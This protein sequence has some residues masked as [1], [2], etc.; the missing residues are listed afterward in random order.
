MC[1]SDEFDAIA[2]KQ[3]REAVYSILNQI[4][5]IGWHS[6]DPL[7]RDEPPS[8]ERKGHSANPQRGAYRH[9]LPAQRGGKIKYLLE[10][11]VGLHRKQIAYMKRQRPGACT[12]FK[13]YP[14]CYLL[15]NEIGLLDIDHDEHPEHA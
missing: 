6:L 9:R 5:E 15:Q 14:Q 1:I 4:I 11:Y 8:D 2:D 7:H 3:I 13:N 12:T 10:E